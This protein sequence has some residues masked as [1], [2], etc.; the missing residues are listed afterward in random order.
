L[1][2]SLSVVVLLAVCTQVQAVV[3]VVFAQERRQYFSVERTP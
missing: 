3:L 1:N 2:I